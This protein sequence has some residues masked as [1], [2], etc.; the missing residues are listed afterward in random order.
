MIR[1]EDLLDKPADVQKVIRE[2]ICNMLA[3]QVGERD[4][5]GK[6]GEIR[7]GNGDTKVYFG[8]VMS[9]MN[10]K[11]SMLSLDKFARVFNLKH[12]FSAH[13]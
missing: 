5:K 4:V 11:I 8:I 1:S 9:A 6:E 3:G 12:C 2:I 10:R 13:F 7:A